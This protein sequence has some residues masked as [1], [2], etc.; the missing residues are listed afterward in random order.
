MLTARAAASWT[1]P[2]ATHAAFCQSN[3]PPHSSQV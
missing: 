3:V 2:A 1:D